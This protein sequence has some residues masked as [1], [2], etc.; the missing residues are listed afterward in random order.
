MKLHR[1]NNSIIQI[2]SVSAEQKFVFVL[3]VLR[4]RQSSQKRSQPAE[5]IKNDNMILQCI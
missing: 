5:S 4:C 1:T 3:Q 2:S